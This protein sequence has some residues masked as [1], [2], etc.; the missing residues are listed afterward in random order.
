MGESP[1]GCASPPGSFLWGMEGRRCQKSHGLL[2]SG[3]GTKN[4]D[5]SALNKQLQLNDF[6]AVSAVPMACEPNVQVRS[7]AKY[8]VTGIIMLIP[9]FLLQLLSNY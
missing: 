9:G 5:N 7:D 6:S 1:S 2:S 4:K 8:A 3:S